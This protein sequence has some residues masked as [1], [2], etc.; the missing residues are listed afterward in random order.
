MLYPFDINP[1]AAGGQIG[2]YKMMQKYP[3]KITETLAHGYSVVAIPM[4]TNTYDR[5]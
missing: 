3:E 2:R 1:Y 4:N 5:V